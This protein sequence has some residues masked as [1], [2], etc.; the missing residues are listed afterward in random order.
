MVRFRCTTRCEPPELFKGDVGKL[1][2]FAECTNS[3]RVKCAILAWHAVMAA[4]N[5]EGQTAAPRPK[6]L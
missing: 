6:P 2:V 1:A 3:T 4:L 5:G